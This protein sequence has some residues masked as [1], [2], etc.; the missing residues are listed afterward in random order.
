MDK[1]EF[2]TIF[3]TFEN[4][5]VVRQTLPSII[6]ETR[7]NDARLI[8]HDSSVRNRREKW[9]YLLE[10]NKDHDFHL[11][12]SDNMSMAHARNMCLSLG[13]ELFAPDYIC[14]V[15][16]DHGFHPGLIPAMIENMRKYYG[17]QAPNGLRYGL[18]SGC[19]IHNTLDRQALVDGN[20][21]PNA[22]NPPDELGRANSCFRCAPSQ[23]W[24]NVLKGYDTD[25]Y[26]ISVYQTANLNFRN[27]NKGFTTLIVQ[28][29]RLVFDI[30]ATG[31]GFTST[32][33]IRLWDEKYTA[34]DRRS[35]YLGKST[36]ST[37]APDN[38]QELNRQGEQLAA[39]GD[40]DGALNCFTKALRS[41]PGNP[42]THNN[43]AVAKWMT[44]DTE[45]ALL[46]IT[47]AIEGDPHNPDSILNGA[48]IL[49]AL[50]QA[51]MA[52]ALCRNYVDA[53]PHHEQIEK[54]L[55]LLLAEESKAGGT[56]NEI[57][58]LIQTKAGLPA[59]YDCLRGRDFVLLSFAE[60]TQDTTLYYPD[61]TW[62]SGR[63]R[64][65]EYALNLPKHYKYY[66]FL[67]DDIVF[68]NCSQE[69]GFGQF[70]KQLMD[71]DFAVLTP[72]HWGYNSRTSNIEGIPES[73]NR[74]A[75]FNPRFE[76]QTVD[77]FDAAFNAFRRDVFT[78]NNI[79]PYVEDF[80]A[81][82]WW[83]SQFVFILKSNL[84]WKNRIVQ[85]NLL[86]VKNTG[87]DRTTGYL[88]GN[89]DFH[90]GYALVAE[91][92]KGGNISMS[93]AI[94]L[95]S[96]EVLTN[97]AR[98][99]RDMK[100]VDKIL[101]I[102]RELLSRYEHIVF[103]DVGSANGM[104]LERL[105]LPKVY[106][107]GIDP[108]MGRYLD[109]ST[110][111]PINRY[112]EKI[113]AAIDTGNESHVSFNVHQ[114]LACSSRLE[115]NR[116]QI[117]SDPLHRA[118]KFY[119]P[120]DRSG[121][122]VVEDN[123]LVERKSLIDIIGNLDLEND[124]IHFLKVDAQGVDL[125]VIKS[126]GDFLRDNVLFVMIETTS[127]KTKN[128]TL[129]K[130]SSNFTEDKDYFTSQG[131]R[132][133]TLETLLQDDADALFYNE[134]ILGGSIGEIFSLT[135]GREDSCHGQ[136]ESDPDMKMHAQAS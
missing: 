60:K 76:Y 46:H 11:I 22:T 132:L 110:E 30:D 100:G 83:I 118:D 86:T 112:S 39:A 29:G 13:Q 111:T 106:S 38:A 79:F 116:E 31:R 40:L 12:L 53:H 51:D 75:L 98:M 71:G 50:D 24:H 120:E 52:K 14:M 58:Y 34:S 84:H 96:R 68:E 1:A 19:G 74:K 35:H 27:Y 102:V 55:L 94:E 123:L 16:D 28:D 7:R 97:V 77:W 104:I 107:I 121:A 130:N 33:S 3:G 105:G 69:E 18:F 49:I 126:C 61:S 85:S 109:R 48:Q 103:I 66:A 44:N 129:Y 17:K 47:K 72:N 21:C 67:D 56:D 59:I 87:H 62:T 88:G 92:A 99:T 113:S 124:V 41:D 93:G 122:I 82:S 131:F 43:L 37:P 128:G 10:L 89:E 136:F 73:V 65:R 125:R 45:S 32:N 135:P 80:D 20:S 108:L 127:E 6:E 133:I 78:D 119:L 5:D 15:E 9:D 2:L 54:L 4:L 114:E 36:G 95:Y 81:S 64:L 57:L 134:S 8:V 91:Q 25:E 23:H 90:K 115:V 101:T 26:L 70:E 63:N 117:V 42:T